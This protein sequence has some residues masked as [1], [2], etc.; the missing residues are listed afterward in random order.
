M[1]GFAMAMPYRRGDSYEGI[2]AAD[3]QHD[4]DGYHDDAMFR[5]TM[6]PTI[7]VA[8]MVALL[9]D[10]DR[11]VPFLVNQFAEILNYLSNNFSYM[12]G[13]FDS[14][15]IVNESSAPLYDDLAS[16]PGYMI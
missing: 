3:M 14:N 8:L 13:F 1:Q 10:H 12:D 16:L 6:A 11:L 15:Q 4:V 7:F 2:D 9:I 5:W